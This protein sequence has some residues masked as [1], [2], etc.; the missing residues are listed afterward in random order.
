MEREYREAVRRLGLSRQQARI[1]ELLMQ[2]KA[3][4]EIAAKLKL[5]KHTVRTYL[6]RISQ[7]LG[8]SGRVETMLAIVAIT[9]SGCPHAR[10]PYKQ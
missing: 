7:R 9:I 3:D 4:K 1:V 8:V 2:G 6:K 5:S 10:C